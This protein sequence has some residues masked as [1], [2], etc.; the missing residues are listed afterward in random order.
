MLD[1]L[2]N[3]VPNT[4]ED[5]F[6]Y[7][8]PLFTNIALLGSQTQQFNIQADA[9]FDCYSL[10]FLAN[11]AGAATTANTL[12]IPNLLAVLTDSGSGRRLSDNPMPLSS[13]ASNPL[14][15]R[16]LPGG[17]RRF[18]R[19]GTVQLTLTNVDAAVATHQVFVTAI[20]RKVFDLS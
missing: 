5:F 8:F 19:N 20:G 3:G 10:A 18:I 7:E 12:V 14:C 9:D 17:P 6:C 11:I 4:L 1:V 15:V 13:M 16:E 2:V